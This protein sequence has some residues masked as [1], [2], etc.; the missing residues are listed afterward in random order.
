MK[1]IA[2]LSCVLL[3]TIVSAV[4]APANSPEASTS[5]DIAQPISVFYD[6][7]YDVGTTSL[8]TVACSDGINGLESSYATFSSLPK[9]PMIGGAPTIAGWDSPACGKCYQL[10]FQTDKIDETI[11]VLAI[12][13]A[14]G[15]FNIGLKAM[16]SLTNDQAVNLGRVD[17]TY[18]EVDKSL[19]GL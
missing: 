9:F 10:H 19:C 13:T 18:V 12:D 15:G 14:S 5:G 1:Y 7:R 4:P 11:N 17:A 16:N 3:A 2:T 8:S 6:E